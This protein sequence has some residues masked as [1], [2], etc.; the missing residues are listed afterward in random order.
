M[1]N[2]DRIIG[3]RCEVTDDFLVRV[4]RRWMTKQGTIKGY[5]INEYWHPSIYRAFHI[6]F[7][8]GLRTTYKAKDVKIY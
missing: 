6:E 1:N 5:Y 7:D 2:L 4:K 8:D 3:R